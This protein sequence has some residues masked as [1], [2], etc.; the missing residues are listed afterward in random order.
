[1][2]RKICS[3]LLNADTFM[4]T[5]TLETILYNSAHTVISILNTIHGLKTV[6]KIVNKGVFNIQAFGQV[7]LKVMGAV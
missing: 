7:Y 6:S 3:V 2:R 5:N 1:M 4:D